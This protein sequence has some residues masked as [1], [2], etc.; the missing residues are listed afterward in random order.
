MKV[1]KQN[2]TVCFNEEAHTYWNENDNEKYISVTTLIER[3]TQPFD[4]EFWSA[5]KALEKLIPAD[6]WK[7]EKKSLLN[8]RKFN[9]EILDIYDI[10]ELT[11]NKTQQ[12]ILDEWD[13]TNRES[14]ERGTKIHAELENSM[15]KMGA[16]VS[17]KKFGIGGKFICDKGRTKLDLES[18]VYPEYLISRTSKDGILRIAGQID[19]LV[20][21]GN[22]IIICDWK[23]VPL[24]T[25]IGTPEGWT[26]MKD[27]KEGD[28]VFDRDGNITTVLHKSNIHHNPC[29]KITFDNSESIVAD[30]DH[31]WIISFK[32]QSKKTPY[33]EKIM[34]TEELSYYLNSIKDNRNTY[35]IPKILNPKPL[36]LEHS[37][38]PLDPYVLGC[39]LG[40]GSKQC[41]IITNNS[42]NIWNEIKNRGYE[43]GN[44]I[45][46]EDRCEAHTVLGIYPILK[47]LNLINNK[48]IPNMYLRASYQQR[49][50]LLRGLMDTDGYYH[51]KRKRFVMET[52]QEWQKD[53]ML[54]LLGSL[55]I[56]PT[57]FFNINKIGDKEYPGWDI[58]FSTNELNPF[59]SRNQDISF[60][61]TDKNSFR[62]IIS[63]ES[64]ETVPTQ[65]IEVDSPTHTYLI[66]YTMIVT[67]NT[68]KEIKTHS[69]FDTKTKSTAKML[70][71]LNTLEDCNFNHYTL[72]LSTY[73]WMVKKLNPNFVIKDL[74]LV[75]FDHQ[76]N[77]TIYKLP[78]LEKEVEKM[79]RYYKKQVIR[80]KQK[81][82][83]KRIEY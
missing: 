20:K 24:D 73:A 39:W 13:Q 28:K 46:A 56:K 81:E 59:L 37:N 40:D 78:Y 36:N 23:G 61:N 60:P 51:P 32:T 18:G 75:H 7:M 77:Q 83:Y 41:G 15:Y 9:K 29:Y 68:N 5:Y 43:I 19:L 34:T 17:L 44:D 22:E 72:Q 11:F 26:T 63:V 80:E 1:D 65:C 14:C 82:K 2:G 62:N 4:K 48:H 64:I 27:L 49:L 69:G 58:C 33:I 55:G 52:D 57:V 8:T 10:D 30:K 31:K 42:N 6:N 70:Y 53:G 66:G 45:S 25:P 3:F 12:D 67:H 79:L 35:N 54:M 16:N 21:N 50:D 76:G 74:I 38:L 71:P 47:F